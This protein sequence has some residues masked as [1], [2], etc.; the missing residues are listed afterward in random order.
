MMTRNTGW[1]CDRVILQLFKRDET[2][3]GVH[4]SY[5][6]PSAKIANKGTIHSSR[7]WSSRFDEYVKLQLKTTIE[8]AGLA[9][10]FT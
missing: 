5:L 1:N 2:M 4:N 3:A 9:D 10:D 7:I 8:K 6:I